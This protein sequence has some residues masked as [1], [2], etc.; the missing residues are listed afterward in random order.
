MKKFLKNTLILLGVI[1]LITNT[2]SWV[3]LKI[4]KSSSFY[5]PGF[6]I[7]DVKEK[8]LDYIIIGASTGLTT[9]NTKV[10]DSVSDLSG[11]NLCMDDT[12]LPTHYLMLEHYINSGKS[13]KMCI[14]S[15]S[16]FSYS[17][18]I[19][20][21]SDNDHRFL[22]FISNNYVQEHYNNFKGR[23][24]RILEVSKWLPVAGVS[25]YNVELFYPSLLSILNKKKRNRFDAKGNYTYPVVKR[26]LLE[27]SDRK[28]L[29]LNLRNPYLQKIKELCDKNNIKL[30]CYLSPMENTTVKLADS[31]FHFI[32][33]SSELLD[34]KYFYDE[35]H[36]NSL[37]RG[38]ISEVF[39]QNLKQLNNINE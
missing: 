20:K 32:N 8:D 5:K 11:I 33:H 19:E 23:Q 10:I 37:G 31:N 15:P 35:I 22:P 30:I 12:S 36:V 9:L 27:K 1:F 39:A 25:Y 34:R 16:A 7:N 17:K 14:L 28:D 38:I 3:S 18:P 26:I 13:V 24:A 21:L 4:M 29:N 2:F 6:L